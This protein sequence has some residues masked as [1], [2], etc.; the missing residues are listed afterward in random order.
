[1]QAYF[2][3]D[4]IWNNFLAIVKSWEGTPYRHLTMV[5][6]GG[7]DCA[8]FIGAC[9]LEAGILKELTYDY[10]ARD[11]HIHTKNEYVI[12]SLFKH[13]SNQAAPGFEIKR[14]SKRVQKIRGDLLTFATTPQGV[15]NH[16]S[17]YLGQNNNMMVH[18]IHNRGVSYFPFKGF[19][20]KKLTSIFRIEKVVKW[21]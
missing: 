16:A 2:R 10:H 19:F 3:N 11:W 18:S 9:W 17:I 7:A 13:F 12:D 21:L 8:L 5:K 15:G 14:M 20:E 4:K 1:M 6:G